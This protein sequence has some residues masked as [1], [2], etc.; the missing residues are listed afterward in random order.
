MERQYPQDE[1]YMKKIAT[2]PFF[3]NEVGQNSKMRAIYAGAKS[4][5]RKALL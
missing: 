3:P 2:Q 5:K 4:K 1:T